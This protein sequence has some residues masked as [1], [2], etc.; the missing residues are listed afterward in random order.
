M[1]EQKIERISEF[2]RQHGQTIDT[3]SK[4]RLSQLEKIDD[5]IQLKINERIK[6]RE[7]LKSNNINISI[8]S[9][10]S[11]ISR[12]TFYNNELLKEYVEQYATDSEDKKVPESELERVKLKN[13]ELTKQINGFVLRDIETENLRHENSELNR[14]IQNLQIRNE[15]LENQCEKLQMELSKTKELLANNNII[16]FPK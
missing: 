11:G 9:A 5:V 15:S 1:D 10:E 14:E 3:I 13:E 6:A 2:L 7:I 16:S 8:I 4:S 12:K